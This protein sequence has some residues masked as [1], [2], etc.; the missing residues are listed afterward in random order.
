MSALKARVFVGTL[1][2]CAA[3]VSA[4]ANAA[5]TGR[6]VYRWVDDQ[7][8]VHYGDA[9]PPQYAQKERAVLNGRGIVINRLEAQKSAPQ[10]A[11]EVHEQQE[12]AKQ[13]QHDS[14]L[15]STYTS[16]KDIE[17]LRDE[18]LGQLKGQR[19][20]AELYVENLRSRLTALQSRALT[21]KPY[22]ARPD[23]RRMPDDLA[24]DLVR[25][26][27]EMRTQS[28]T[29]TAKSEEET[30]LKAQFQADIERYQELHIAH[31]QR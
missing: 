4:G 13:K 11:A 26:L 28:N 20:A 9:I 2:A 5:G 21:F 16:V 24:E 25:T 30:A 23:A 3:L 1:L 29:L 15:M 12:V 8:V 7:G 22:N 19:V 17:S 18:R 27:N 14:F 31:A 10:L 6:A